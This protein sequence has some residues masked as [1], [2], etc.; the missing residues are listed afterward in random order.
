MNSG[1]PRSGGR[2]RRA[3]AASRRCDTRPRCWMPSLPVAPGEWPECV[4]VDPKGREAFS[5]SRV[6]LPLSECR[7]AFPIRA[8]MVT[9]GL[10]DPARVA[11]LGAVAKWVAKLRCGENGPSNI[12]LL[13]DQQ[14]TGRTGAIASANPGVPRSLR[15]NRRGLPSSSGGIAPDWPLFGLPVCS[16]CTG[17]KSG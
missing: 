1:S 7:R 6:L 10:N 2:G 13:R 12:L 16:T 11:C 17:V 4:T 3:C 5:P 15:R 8:P 9:A 14:Y